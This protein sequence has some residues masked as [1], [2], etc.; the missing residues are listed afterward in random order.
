M[1]LYGLWWW[2]W[3]LED[4]INMFTFWSSTVNAVQCSAEEWLCPCMQKTGPGLWVM[5]SF[6]TRDCHT[7][8]PPILL[9]SCSFCSSVLTTLHFLAGI[10]LVL[11][12]LLFLKEVVKCFFLQLHY[13]PFWHDIGIQHLLKFLTAKPYWEKV[14]L[15]FFSRPNLLSRKIYFTLKIS[16]HLWKV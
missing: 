2:W 8:A 5:S 6:W 4:L 13:T 3:H 12:S 9:S 10:L 16:M 15:V 1:F 7:P 11:F 14:L